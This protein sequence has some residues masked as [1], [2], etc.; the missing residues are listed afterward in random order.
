MKSSRPQKT[1]QVFCS[2]AKVTPSKLLLAL[3]LPKACYH[4]HAKQKPL[5]LPA[6]S[7]SSPPLHRATCTV[8]ANNLPTQLQ[9]STKEDWPHPDL[10]PKAGAFLLQLLHVPLLQAAL[11]QV[12]NHH[13]R[14]VGICRHGYCR[15]SGRQ[16]SRLVCFRN[17]DVLTEFK[18]VPTACAV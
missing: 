2:T 6:G 13:R 5:Q 9:P 7:P 15:G 8:L 1:A 12:R 11:L 10:C 3:A 17:S 18:T 14:R 16:V 4:P